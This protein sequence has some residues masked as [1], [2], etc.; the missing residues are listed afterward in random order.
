ML[1]YDKSIF[2]VTSEA[3]LKLNRLLEIRYETVFLSLILLNR[4]KIKENKKIAMKKYKTSKN[5][6][7]KTH[8]QL[9]RVLHEMI[10]VAY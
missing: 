5:R 6:E 2:L 9:Q 10:N 1:L 8:I 7:K 4:M 3:P